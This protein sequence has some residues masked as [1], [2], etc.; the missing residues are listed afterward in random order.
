MT[1][2]SFRV[3]PSWQHKCDPHGPRGPSVWHACSR[4]SNNSGFS[5]HHSAREVQKNLTVHKMNKRPTNSSK[6][7]C[8]STSSL[9]YMFR[10][11]RG[12]IFREFSMSSVCHESGI[13]WGL[14]IVTVCV[15]GCYWSKDPNHIRIPHPTTQTVTIYSPHPIPLSWH[16]ELILNSLKIAPLMRRNV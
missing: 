2:I 12:A 14:Y 7:Q 8:I 6:N 11:I 10:R 5:W 15:V 3:W 1:S 13:G 16:T 4:G 9:S